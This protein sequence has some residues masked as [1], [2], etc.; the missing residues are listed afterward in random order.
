WCGRSGAGPGPSH[1]AADGVP[2]AAATR[3]ARL[4]AVWAGRIGQAR[5]FVSGGARRPK[6]PVWLARV[7]PRT[8]EARKLGFI[9]TRELVSEQHAERGVGVLGRARE[10]LAVALPVAPLAREQAASTCV[11][12]LLEARRAEM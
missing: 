8:L 6:L 3:R 4:P 10:I 12:F 9:G 11:D 7:A 1:R 2:V 5:H